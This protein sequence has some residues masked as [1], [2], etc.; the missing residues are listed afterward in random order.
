MDRLDDMRK[1]KPILQS[2]LFKLQK[3]MKVKSME[4]TS[5]EGKHPHLIINKKAR[6]M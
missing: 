5:F 6:G 2:F 1:Y 3:M 4:M